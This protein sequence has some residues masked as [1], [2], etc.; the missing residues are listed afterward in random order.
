[1]VKRHIGDMESQVGNITLTVSKLD[2]PQ[3]A[4]TT[5]QTKTLAVG[6]DRTDFRAS[7]RL[8]R[9]KYGGTDGNGVNNTFTRLGSNTYEYAL[10]GDR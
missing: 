5:L 9:L 8:L 6:D 4:E 3:G 2:Y 1:M 7:G 10:L